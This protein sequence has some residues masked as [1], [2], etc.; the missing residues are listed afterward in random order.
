MPCRAVPSRAKSRKC[1]S[2]TGIDC[3]VCS[4]GYTR[5]IGY[6]CDKCSTSSAGLVLMAVL[7]TAAVVA[8]IFLG[9]YMMSEEHGQDTRRGFVEHLMRY[10]PLQSVKIVI[11]AWQILTQVRMV[12]FLW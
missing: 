6:R 11:V 12:I 9:R 3:S 10:I 7:V 5:S 4:D 8:I 1:S 2:P